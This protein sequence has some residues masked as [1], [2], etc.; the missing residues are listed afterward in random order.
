MT[1]HKAWCL[2]RSMSAEL[3]RQVSGSDVTMALNMGAR[4]FLEQ[5]Y[6]QYIRS[7]LQQHRNQ[8]SEL[9]L[10]LAA[11]VPYI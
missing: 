8:V 9:P 4:E 10:M 2:L 3:Q 1:M 6:R 5:S 7:F 11:N